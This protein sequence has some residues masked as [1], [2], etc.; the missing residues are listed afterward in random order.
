MRR[1]ELN[2]PLLHPSPAFAKPPVRGLGFLRDRCAKHA[3]LL[4]SHRAK[5]GRPFGWVW[6]GRSRNGPARQVLRVSDV[7]P[8]P[9]FVE[10][11]WEKRGEKLVGDSNS[12]M[13]VDGGVDKRVNFWRPFG[14]G[15]LLDP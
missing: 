6:Y 10:M 8:R 11:A 7:S 3:P 9:S 14:V 13:E 4:G 1:Y 2:T 12:L 5:R 15:Q